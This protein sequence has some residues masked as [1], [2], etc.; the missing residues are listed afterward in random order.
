M[1]DLQFGVPLVIADDL[2]T[3]ERTSWEH[4]LEIALLAEQMGFDTIWIP[5]ELFWR[6]EEGSKDGIGWW[7]GVAM[8]GA[9]AAA[10]TTIGIGT[11]V[12]SALHRNPGLTVKAIETIDEIS[13]GRTIF[14]Y[15]AGHAEDQGRTFGYPLEKT[16]GRY[17]EAL[18]IVVPLLRAGHAEF[19]GEYHS[20]ADQISRPRGP[21]GSAI[22]LL[23]GGHG[24]RTIGLAARYA[25]IWSGYSQGSSAPESYVERIKLLDEACE[26]IGRDPGSIGRSASAVVAP[27]GEEAPGF[28]AGELTGSPQQIAEDL[29][30]FADVGITSVEIWLWPYTKPTLEAMAP[31]MEIVR[32]G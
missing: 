21:Q 5:D 11:W 20:A 12:L 10:T 32:A 25:D 17:E 22:P 24:P 27:T 30:R 4:T 2:T 9:L 6:N 8:A 1:T 14:G 18:Q 16:V 19:S 7:E 13:G 23:L 3:Q 28:L 26:R 29:L 15:G 31:V